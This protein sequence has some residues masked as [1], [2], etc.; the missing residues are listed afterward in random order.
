MD[1]QQRAYES[2][3]DE[4]S[5]RVNVFS[6]Y[7]TDSPSVLINWINKTDFDEPLRYYN[8]VKP[9]YDF[10]FQKY[11]KDCKID[12]KVMKLVDRE[13]YFMRMMDDDLFVD[14]LPNYTRDLLQEELAR[15]IFSNEPLLIY[16]DRVC[17]GLVKYNWWKSVY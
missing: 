4:L 5:V 10:A 16:F 13:E 12:D 3:I 15:D 1:L 6:S 17:R 9:H 7:M 11:M 8:E 14:S 2:S